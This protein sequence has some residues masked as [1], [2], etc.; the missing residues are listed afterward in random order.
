MRGKPLQPTNPKPLKPSR[1]NGSKDVEERYLRTVAQTMVGF[2]MRFKVPSLMKGVWKIWERL[3][4]GSGKQVR[5]RPKSAPKGSS[6]KSLT[7]KY[8]FTGCRGLKK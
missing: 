2:L 8:H 5:S 6:T 3:L 1:L 4:V 7:P